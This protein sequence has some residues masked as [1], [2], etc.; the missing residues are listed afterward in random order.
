MSWF[1]QFLTSSIGRKLLMSLTGLFLV[2]FLLIHLIGNLQL[3]AGDGGE[4]F[5]HYAEFMA[6][7]PLIQIVSKGLYFFILLHAYQGI[8]LWIKNRA[9]RGNERYAV[10]VTRAVNTN[11][12]A[13]KNMAWLGI[14]IF[15]FL[16]I[17]MGQFW[18]KMKFGGETDLYSLVSML[19][20][21]PVWVVFYI[22]CMVIVAVHLWHGFQSSFQTLGLNH[23]KYSPLIRF[24]GKAYSILIPLG[25]AMIP[26]IMFLNK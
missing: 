11:S 26:I 1:T 17:H 23:P 20:T 6:H 19:Y 10:Q 21:N 14:I 18:A 22:V 13:A 5:N 15:I 3:L 7:N 25:F 8:V 4:S 24:V 12:F 2:I 9:A 16:I